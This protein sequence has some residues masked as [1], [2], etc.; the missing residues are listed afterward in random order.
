MLA[1]PTFVFAALFCHYGPLLPLLLCAIRARGLWATCAL[2]LV[3]AACLKLLTA[4]QNHMLVAGGS[5]PALCLVWPQLN[6]QTFLS[7]LKP[8]LSYTFLSLNKKLKN[9]P[10]CLIYLSQYS[11]LFYEFMARIHKAY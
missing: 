2:C 9:L 6:L 1:P 3:F 5:R 8:S 10:C 11:D 7:P 4:A